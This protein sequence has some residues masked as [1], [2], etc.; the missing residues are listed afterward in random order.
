MASDNS[1]RRKPARYTRERYLTS[2]LLGFLI[3]FLCT[4][5]I[6]I[7]EKG[8]FI[9]S[10]DFILQQIPFLNLLN[11]SVRSGQFGWNWLTD[12]GSDLLASY[13]FYLIGSPFFWITVLL[14]RSLVTF[15]IP[16]ILALKHGIAS[17]T[18]YAYIRRFVRNKNA[19]LIGGLLYSFSG[20]QLYNIFFNHFHDVTALFPLM[21]IAMEE[22]INNRR[23]GW[24]A[25]IVAVMA[26]LNYYFF[27]GQ[28]VFLI[29]YYLIRMKAPDFRTSW[30]KFFL[31]LAEALIGTALAAF[32]LLPS[33]LGLLGND[34]INDLL[35]GLD[36][37]IYRDD[38]TIWRI[39]QTFFM[40][41]DPPSTPIL[42]ISEYGKWS[43]IGG[44]FPLFGMLGV[45]TY[46]YTHRKHWATRMAWLCIIF[47]MIPFLNS[48]FQTANGYYYA[49]WFYMP[50]LIFALMTARSLD[51][52]NADFVPAIKIS[53]VMLAV[54]AIISLLPD[55]A[56]KD[57]V[58][59]F[60]MTDETGFFYITLGIAALSLLI[61]GYILDA[62]KR[63]Y[64]IGAAAVLT[65]AV[66][67][68]GCVCSTIYFMASTPEW[69]ES[70]IRTY[71]D[72]EDTVYEKPANDNFF[73]SDTT[74]TIENCTMIWGLPSIRAFHSV[75]SP[76]IME[77]YNTIG[78]VRDVASRPDM[79]HYTIRGLLSVKYMYRMPVEGYSYSDLRNA[80]KS[81]SDPDTD[82]LLKKLNN[83][84]QKKEIN[85]EKE[86]PTEYLPG[87]EYLTERNGI[88]IYENKLFVPMGFAYDKYIT[89]RRS[90]EMSKELREKLLMKMLVL[91]DEQAEKY[92]D[93]ISEASKDEQHTPS[94]E[95]YEDWCRE[96]QAQSCSSFSYDSH[97]FNAE[98]TLDRPSLVFFSVPYSKGWS[99]KVNGMDTDVEKVSYGFVAVK[100]GKG[101]SKITFDYETPG[102]RT[103]AIISCLA[104]FLLTGFVAVCRITAGNSGCYTSS[105]CYDYESTMGVPG[106][107]LY[108]SP[109]EKKK[110]KKKSSKKTAAK[111]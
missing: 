76:S 21:L 47:A 41:S 109:P 26:V 68:A 94:K 80:E 32:I 75:V 69:A 3:F 44:Y 105:H 30:K 103:G 72:G 85:A 71:I 79:S 106:S 84:S 49:R 46:M 90:D 13:S 77:F 29:L 22:N 51:E 87:F 100:C 86:D 5:P 99:A 28:A 92:K 57:T 60:S 36:T 59:W 74:E 64:R 39:I 42:F 97:G 108:C 54:F 101:T 48:L 4:L 107:Q 83:G 35:Y 8:Y 25:V 16:V 70:Y 88:E 89:D 62:K 91:T 24:F 45:I 2:F 78:V 20:F 34:R 53:A 102:L 37:V 61:A 17:T 18:A 40:P 11:D 58:I 15:S 7:Y 65:T 6:L 19:A 98:I 1:I 82:E 38:T 111:K 81:S 93:I 14:P 52:E 23:R 96:K 50:I 67:S 66:F 31:L 10:G 9:Y 104:F 56:D 43:S 27:C 110:K 63:G 95:D 12:L 73:R 55:K 33:A